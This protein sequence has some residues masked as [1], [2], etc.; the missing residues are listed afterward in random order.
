MILARAEAGRN[1]RSVMD[2]NLREL[3]KDISTTSLA[4]V[5]LV[6]CLFFTYSITESITPQPLKLTAVCGRPTIQECN[7]EI[8]LKVQNE[9]SEK[10]A[11]SLEKL[12]SVKEKLPLVKFIS[13]NFLI[14]IQNKDSKIEM[15]VSNPP[16]TYPMGEIDLVCEISSQPKILKNRQ[17]VPIGSISLSGDVQKDTNSIVGIFNKNYEGCNWLPTKTKYSRDFR[18]E[19]TIVAPNG[20]LSMNIDM[21]AF[22][23][24]KINSGTG[25]LIFSALF[26][27]IGIILA[28][29]KQ[30]L[31]IA[32]K[33]LLYFS[34]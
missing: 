8:K 22:L 2:S 20:I 25:I 4:W 24:F 6:L 18:D 23:V 12:L 16:Q 28:S 29:I 27:F 15:R 32:R 31:E 7:E 9:I 30:F 14:F 26:G 17:L 10:L 1:T 5:W 33:G 13:D 19:K 21:K 34:E 3:K 11:F